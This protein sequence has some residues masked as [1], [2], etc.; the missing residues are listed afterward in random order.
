MAPVK[1][2]RSPTV[3]AGVPVHVCMNANL[4]R[5]GARR[6]RC[7]DCGRTWVVT[8]GEEVCDD[9]RVSPL[10]ARVVRNRR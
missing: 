1:D 9:H 5:V 10:R 7:A 3:V 8:G 4:V 2:E 6:Y